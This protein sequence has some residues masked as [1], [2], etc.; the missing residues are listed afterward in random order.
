VRYY[1]ETLRRVINE[2]LSNNVTLNDTL[3]DGNISLAPVGHV[4]K[5]TNTIKEWLNKNNYNS[6]E[7]YLM[8]NELGYR[9][10]P[11]KLIK[12]FAKSAMIRDLQ[13][14]CNLLEFRVRASSPGGGF[15]QWSDG[16]AIIQTTVP[17]IETPKPPEVM[18]VTTT[19]IL[20][21]WD[22]PKHVKDSGT[23]FKIMGRRKLGRNMV[24]LYMGK[25]NEF[26]V[27]ETGTALIPGTEYEFSLT[28]M[29]NNGKS[30]L[31]FTEL[32]NINC[33]RSCIYKI[34]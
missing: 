34:D 26:N 16:S 5:K 10:L 18:S 17:E 12:R 24:V 3:G 4:E 13:P 1:N 23:T 28:Y 20:L 22:C 32:Q 33:Y 30:R 14:S 9:L 11:E 8:Q 31:L 19:T 27:G 21:K 2:A 25:N 29:L 15:G 6:K 7:K